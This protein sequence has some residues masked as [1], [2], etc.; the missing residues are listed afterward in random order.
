[1]KDSEIRV[2]INVGK[3]NKNDRGISVYT[4]NILSQFDQINGNYELVFLTDQN[5]LIHSPGTIG[6]IINEQV[7]NPFQQE[8]LKL[9]VMWHPHNRGQ[10][11]TPCAYVCTLHD[12]LPLARPDL[13]GNYLNSLSKKLLFL[14]RVITTK[15]ADTII[16]VSEFSR[17]EIIKYLHIDP[18][19]V[20]SIHSGVNT[21]TFHR[22]ESDQNWEQLKQSQSLPDRYILTTGSYAPH[23]NL[24]T[25]VEAYATS[26]L[27]SS[28]VGLL[29]V[30]PN[31]ASGY[32]AGYNQVADQV[33][34]LN[35]SNKVRLLSSVS[36]SD[37]VTLYSRATFFALTSLY[38]GF[39]FTP[40]E[41]MACG[42]P[43]IAS[44]LAS[45]PEVCGNAALYAD[46]NDPGHFTRQFNTLLRDENLRR[47]LVLNGA[48]QVQKFDWRDSAYKTLEVLV[49]AFQRRRHASN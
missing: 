31:D 20:V 29:M 5:K 47:E 49:S 45:I 36:E 38:E 34:Q 37:L 46:P 10:L 41:A 11:F 21:Q 23:K 43:V 13:A 8:R 44:S 24:K 28:G 39:G 9:D 27:P 32:R 6:S 12:V 42:V 18:N 2:G 25:L 33:R 22:D 4:R 7:S 26:D 1:M 40:L 48:K 19:K 16:T 35:L 30:G 15:A 17:Q 14:S 3:M